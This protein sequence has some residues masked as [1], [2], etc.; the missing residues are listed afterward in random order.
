MRS[1]SLLAVEQELRQVLSR[2]RLV[3]IQ[4]RNYTTPTSTTVFVPLRL[5]PSVVTPTSVWTRGAGTSRKFLGWRRQPFS[6][7]GGD[8]RTGLRYKSGDQELGETSTMHQ[9]G[10][11]IQEVPL[12]VL[13]TKGS[14]CEANEVGV[15]EQNSPGNQIK[16]SIS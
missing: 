10:G 9:E 4:C 11:E 12:A 7:L 14:D 1:S 2:C 5:D 13:K 16:L 8:D 15:S 3:Q 6:M